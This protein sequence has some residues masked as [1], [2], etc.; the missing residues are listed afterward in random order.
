MCK[1]WLTCIFRWIINTIIPYE[2]SSILTVILPFSSSSFY[3]CIFPLLV[4]SI[5]PFRLL[6]HQYFHYQ[7]TPLP[8]QWPPSTFLE[9]VIKG[10]NFPWACLHSCTQNDLQGMLSA[11][12]NWVQSVSWNQSEYFPLVWKSTLLQ[13]WDHPKVF[14]L[15]SLPSEFWSLGCGHSRREGK[16][17][18]AVSLGVVPV[19]P[20]LFWR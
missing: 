20:G 5:T 17:I 16:D 4:F 10:E 2:F 14:S 13:S 11:I 12:I 7:F 8:S 19:E 3:V 6:V 18:P 1:Y 15:P 9:Y